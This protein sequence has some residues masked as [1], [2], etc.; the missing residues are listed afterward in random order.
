VD[1]ENAKKI[2]SKETIG[3]FSLSDLSIKLELK[4]KRPNKLPADVSKEDVKIV[5]E[6]YPEAFSTKKTKTAK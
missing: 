3:G 6:K 2:L 1:F 5:K 4:E